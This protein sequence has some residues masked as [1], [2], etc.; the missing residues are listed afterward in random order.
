MSDEKE[1][2]V[3]RMLKKIGKG[4]DEAGQHVK[5][6]VEDFGHKAASTVSEAAHIAGKKAVEAEDEIK[7]GAA[8]AGHAV[9]SVAEA[10]RQ[11]IDQESRS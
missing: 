5:K 7:T 8:D 3:D 11:E 9:K 1:N 6:E 4:A 10:T 2:I